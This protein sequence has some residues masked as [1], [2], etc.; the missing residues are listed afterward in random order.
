MN[1]I[2]LIAAVAMCASLAACGTQVPAGS[3]G[4]KVRDTGANAGIEPV[5]LSTGWH[6]RGWKEY[7]VIVPVTQKIYPFQFKAEQ[8]T[9]PGGEQIQFTDSTGL[10]LN[11]DVAVTVRIDKSKAP[12]IY[13]KYRKNVD[14]LIH[15]EVRMAVRSAIRTQASKYTSEQIYSGAE[16][17]ILHDALIDPVTGLQAKFAKEG[18]EIIALDW[19]GNIRY[20]QTILDAIT[21]KTATM[22]LAEA[23]KADEIRAV[24]QANADIAKARG[25]AESTR[26]RGVALQSNPQILQQEWIA[27]WD[28]KLPQTVLGSNTMMMVQPK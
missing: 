20:P 14:E 15:T 11:G 25:D 19:I 28:G 16:R 8:D 6:W 24:A 12:A 22:Q 23:A 18:I 2:K 1:K 17:N 21:K 3:A 7:I 10:Q 27:K 9:S 13:D 26:I 5:P 4:I